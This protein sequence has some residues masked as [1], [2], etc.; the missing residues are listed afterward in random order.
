M[1]DDVILPPWAKDAYEF[2][3]LHRLALESEQVSQHL[4]HWIDL[5]FGYKQRG[6]AAVK[7]TNVFYY[8]TYEGAVD[9]SQVS[10]TDHPSGDAMSYRACALR[11]AQWE[12]R[13]R[14]L[15]TGSTF[16]FASI[17]LWQD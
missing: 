2:V 3:R 17:S 4:H 13:V 14:G 15:A 11:W 5:V 6:P 7:A 9:L 10:T 1:V 12:A 8:L 16:G